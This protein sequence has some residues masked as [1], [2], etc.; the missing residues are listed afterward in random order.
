MSFVWAIAWIVSGC[1]VVHSGGGWMITLFL[2]A[3]CDMVI[4][5]RD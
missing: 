4:A 2:V 3:I 5:I 1:P